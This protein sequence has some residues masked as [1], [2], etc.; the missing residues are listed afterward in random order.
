MI[1]ARTVSLAAAL[2]SAAPALAQTEVAPTNLDGA[3]LADAS[4]VIVVTGQRPEYGIRSTR[5]ATRTETELKDIPQALTVI[6][7][8]QIED[9]AL[10]SIA[11][12]WMSCRSDSGTGEGNRDQITL[13]ATTH[14]GFLCRWHARRR[15]ILRDL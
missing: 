3:E 15:P 11:D 10:R 1:I 9:Q 6:S 7:E 12:V 5:S 13:R 14:R 2:A 8:R 4:D